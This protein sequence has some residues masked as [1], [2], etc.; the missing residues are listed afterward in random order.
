LNRKIW[1]NIVIGLMILLGPA[2]QYA[3]G[4]MERVIRVR[5]SGSTAYGLPETLPQ[6]EG[7]ITL[8]EPDLIGEVVWIRR[9]GVKN[10]QW[11][12]MLVVDCAGHADGGYEWMVRNGIIAE[13]DYRTAKEYNTIGRAI[14]ITIVDDLSELYNLR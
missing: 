14:N 12:S 2:S 1:Y 4:V 9:M 6:T 3:P 8:K 13:I 10:D 11:R 5:Q 7:Y